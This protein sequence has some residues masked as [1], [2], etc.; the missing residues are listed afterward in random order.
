MKTFLGRALWLAAMTLA[1]LCP[2]A[3]QA[4]G[5]TPLWTNIFNGAG[6]SGDD[7]QSVVVDGSG[8]VIVTGSSYGT[9]SSY[10]YATI[11]YSSAGL[12]LWT[13]IFNGAANTDSF[14]RSVAADGSGNVRR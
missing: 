13:N 3:I 11:K 12:L 2:L 7:A 9:G 1:F 8:N 5:G 4:A 6:N 10:D 14:A